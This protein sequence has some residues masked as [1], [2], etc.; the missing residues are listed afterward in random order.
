MLGVGVIEGVAVAV[1][2]LLGVAVAVELAV[3]VALGMG[4]AVGAGASKNPRPPEQ[5]LM[6]RKVPL[7]SRAA[8]IGLRLFP[9]VTSSPIRRRWPAKH[10]SDDSR[11][12]QDDQWPARTI[13]FGSASMSVGSDRPQ[14]ANDGDQGHGTDRDHR[15]QGDARVEIT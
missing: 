13:A 4:V 15:P 3:A 8:T 9:T 1:G 7:R 10:R 2:V 14:D 12:S 6:A 5:P 11:V